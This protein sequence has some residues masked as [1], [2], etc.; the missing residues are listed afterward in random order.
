VK[1]IYVTVS[2]VVDSLSS[3]SLSL[4]RPELIAKVLVLDVGAVIE[5]RHDHRFQ[6]LVIAPR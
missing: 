3:V 6:G 2:V 5:D 4:V 1:V